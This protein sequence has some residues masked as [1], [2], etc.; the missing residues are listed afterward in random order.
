MT[1]GEHQELFARLLPHLLLKLHELGY[2]ARIGDVF[3]HDGHRK[4]S[5]HYIKLAVDIN[6]FKDGQF[7]TTTDDHLQLGVFW[8]S[9]NPLCRWGG[10]FN[11]GNHYSIEY[12][13]RK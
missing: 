8:E 4:G 6:L 11:D 7:L 10:R 1:L 12:E 3:A 5:C 9:L 13:G 2:Q